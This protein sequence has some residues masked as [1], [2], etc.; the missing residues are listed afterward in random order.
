MT[1]CPGYLNLDF[2]TLIAIVKSGRGLCNLGV[3]VA[4]GPNR[5]KLASEQLLGSTGRTQQHGIEGALG[6]TACGREHHGH[7]GHQD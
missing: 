7:D 6:T 4:S 3:G 5:V 1:T 2:A